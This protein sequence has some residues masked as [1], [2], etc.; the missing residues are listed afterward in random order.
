[1]PKDGFDS[2]T[3]PKATIE[4]LRTV[5]RKYRRTPAQQLDFMLRFY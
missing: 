2:L 5:A 1:M 3:L 4:R